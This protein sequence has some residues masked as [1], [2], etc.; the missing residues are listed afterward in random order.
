[1][2]NA[3]RI[4]IGKPARNTSLRKRLTPKY[5][6]KKLTALRTWFKLRILS[7]GIQRRVIRLKLNDVSKEY[8]A[9]IFIAEKSRKHEARRMKRRQQA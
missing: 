2:G 5:L 9:S 8:I 7:S 3:Y 4:L 6:S 1:M